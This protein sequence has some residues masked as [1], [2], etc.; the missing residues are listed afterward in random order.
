MTL[1][2]RSVLR[3]GLGAAGLAAV[4]GVGLA[5]HTGDL[6]A[7][8][9]ALQ[10]L[11]AHTHAVVAAV[12]ATML[13]AGPGRPDPIAL[14]IPALV[15]QHMA[16]MH[17]ADQ[18][19]L[20]QGILLL[21]NALVGLLMDGR[22][23]TFS[24]SDPDTRRATLEAWRTSDIEVRRVVYKALRGLIVAAYWGHPELYAAAGYPG[25]PSFTRGPTPAPDAGTADPPAL[26]AEPPSATVPG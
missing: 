24:A 11:D 7:P 19:E 21:D 23:R 17:P 8:P 16:T 22:P 14:G 12:A 26:D 18:A 6:P 2:R 15:D 9:G 5:L 1:T 20:V 4:G 13:P 3:V 10:V 25:P